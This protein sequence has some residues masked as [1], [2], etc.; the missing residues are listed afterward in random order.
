MAGL[1]Q[2]AD[3]EDMAGQTLLIVDDNTN[4]LTVLRSYMSS[5]AGWDTV[6]TAGDAGRAL[7]LA[8]E[9]APAAIVLDN[10]M[11][12]GDGIEVLSDMRRACPDARIVMHTSEDTIDLRD[13]AERLGA[14]AIVAKGLPLDELAALLDVA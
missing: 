1:G 11:P 6:L 3:H 7:L 2:I 9:H 4:L 8:T 13:A 10:R 14:D 12:G 5:I